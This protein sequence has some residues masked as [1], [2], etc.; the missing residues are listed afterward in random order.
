MKRKFP[1]ISVARSITFGALLWY[2]LMLCLPASAQQ[3][4][5]VEVNEPGEWRPFSVGQLVASPATGNGP[6]AY[7]KSL[8]ALVGGTALDHYY[9]TADPTKTNT[10]QYG[11]LNF[12]A[13]TNGLIW[14]LTTARFFD[15]G[16]ASGDWQPEVQTQ[17]QLVAGGWRVIASDVQSEDGYAS[18]GQNTNTMSWLLFERTCQAGERFSIRTEKY[19]SPILLQPRLRPSITSQSSSQTVAVGASA[20]LSVKALGSALTYTWKRNGTVIT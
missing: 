7:W 8:P 15:S 13:V 11:K 3:L 10:V 17:A 4:V 14:M 2:C 9:L 20:V 1:S 19:Q 6:S 5:A 18:P 16:N 12:S